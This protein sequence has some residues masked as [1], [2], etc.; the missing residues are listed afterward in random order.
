MVHLVGGSGGRFSDFEYRYNG[1]VWVI[2][3]D[4]NKANYIGGV[5]DL[6]RCCL[7]AFIWLRIAEC[8]T[9]EEKCGSVFS[10]NILRQ[11]PI[12]TGEHYKGTI[13]RHV[14]NLYQF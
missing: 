12:P 3:S 5:V 10:C 13:S 2:V 14:R 9:T 11:E 7:D 1:I 4:P 6:L 8:D